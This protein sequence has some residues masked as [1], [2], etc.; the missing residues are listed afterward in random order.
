VNG[1]AFYERG[2]EKLIRENPFDH[3]AVERVL[4]AAYKR[5]P[6]QGRRTRT[7]LRKMARHIEHAYEIGY[8]DGAAGNP[9]I[10]REALYK[11]DE[12]LLKQDMHRRAYVAYQSGHRAGTLER[13]EV[14]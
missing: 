2:R 10:S 14:S 8:R 6:M 13:E 4:F 9:L 11:Q 12:S 1:P 5:G 7:F 3:K